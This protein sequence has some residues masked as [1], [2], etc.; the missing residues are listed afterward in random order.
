MKVSERQ[1]AIL[2]YL[3]K[4]KGPVSGADLSKEFGVSRQIIVRDVEALRQEGHEIIST[5]KGYL[6]QGNPGYT[7]IYKVCHKDDEI[8]KELNLIVD[9]GAEVKDVFIYHRIYG[10]VRARLCIQSRRD[11]EEFCRAL[12]EGKSSPLKNATAGFHYHTIEAKN[13]QILELVEE[14]LREAGFLAEV[15]EYEPDTFVFQQKERE[16]NT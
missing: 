5:S 3:R 14:G 13:E 2:Y 16:K 9:L 1:N 11:V 8:R 10:E 7:R 6:Y 15:L 4:E 12:E